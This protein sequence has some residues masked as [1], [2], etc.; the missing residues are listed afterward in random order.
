MELSPQL[1]GQLWF[2]PFIKQEQIFNFQI[3]FSILRQQEMAVDTLMFNVFLKHSYHHVT[4]FFP[5][6]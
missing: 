2:V 5:V 3:H 6:Y 1:T 4:Q